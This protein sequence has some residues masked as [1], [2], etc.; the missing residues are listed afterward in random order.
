MA[1]SEKQ[2]EEKKGEGF[3]HIAFAVEDV[4]GTLG[5]LK[6]LVEFVLIV[7]ITFPDKNN[8]KFG[9]LYNI[10]DL[11]DCWQQIERVTCIKHTS[12]YLLRDDVYSLCNNDGTE[13]TFQLSSNL[14][15]ESRPLRRLS[16]YGRIRMVSNTHLPK[17]T[18]WNALRQ[19]W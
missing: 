4:P 7:S 18:R 2:T 11:F 14:C 17:Y 19:N 10:G 12:S 13:P 5:E 16:R 8:V 15:S 9:E 6:K 1:D 3:H